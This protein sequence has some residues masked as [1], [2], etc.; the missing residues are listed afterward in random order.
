MAERHASCGSLG[1]GIVGMWQHRVKVVQTASKH[2][3]ET[4]LAGGSHN[5]RS[6]VSPDSDDPSFVRPLDARSLSWHTTRTD[7]TMDG[8]LVC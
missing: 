8:S 4:V 2:V 6:S 7:G 3:R 5:V 1:V